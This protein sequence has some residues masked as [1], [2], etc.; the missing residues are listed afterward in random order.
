VNGRD[1]LRAR[2]INADDLEIGV[3]ELRRDRHPRSAAGVEHRVSDAQ[4]RGQLREE[5]E[6]SSG[7]ARGEIPISNLVVAAANDLVSG[8]VHASSIH[9][10]RE[11]R[12][13]IPRRDE[14][15]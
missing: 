4:S 6:V 10:I 14:P 9:G 2:E 15:G 5:R 1:E 8:V 7:D 11:V 13:S 3:D 12:R